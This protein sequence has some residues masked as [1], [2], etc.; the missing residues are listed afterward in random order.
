MAAPFFRLARI[1]Q[2]FAHREVTARKYPIIGNLS[3]AGDRPL[4]PVAMQRLSFDRVTTPGRRDLAQ[5]A[6]TE[7]GTPRPIELFSQELD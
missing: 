7:H 5:P 1:M 2:R 3:A 6:A 4:N